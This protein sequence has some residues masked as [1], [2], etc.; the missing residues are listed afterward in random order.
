MI[1]K[2][3]NLLE[4]IITLAEFKE[5][6]RKIG[7]SFTRNR[8]LPF[9]ELVF[10]LINSCKKSLQI[11]INNFFKFIGED[12]EYSKQALCKARLNILPEGFRELNN[13]W[14]KDVYKENE[15]N[16]FNGYRILA[17]DGTTFELP[18]TEDLKEEF[19]EIKN[20]NGVLKKALGRASIL[21]DV[22]N[23]LVIDGV[24]DKY[25]S[26]E[27]TMAISHLE[28]WSKFKKEIKDNTKDLNIFDRGYPSV[29]LISYMINRDT[30][31]LMRIT[32][33]FLSETNEVISRDGE[34]DEIVEINITK[35]KLKN[36]IRDKRARNEVKLGDKIKVRVLK[37]ML[38]TG[39]YEYL[40]TSL[41]DKESFKKEMFKELY[42]KRW[43][44]ET[45][46]DKLKN[47]L[48]IEN[49][50][51]IKSIVIKQEFY[52]NILVNNMCSEFIDEVQKEIDEES[53]NKNNKYVYIVNR[54]YALGTIKGEFANL[55]FAKP[56]READRIIN[57]I[58]K[59][60]KKDKTPIRDGRSFPRDMDKPCNKYPM[61][62]KRVF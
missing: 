34:V 44:V 52:I 19:G 62:R 30:D 27:R 14:V 22:E 57:R 38:D 58:K 47:T 7:T 45:A 53:K 20:N 55:I 41:L 8:K 61:T 42:F 21:Y 50:S 15:F 2:R 54:N 13:V 36:S 17:I 32:K 16:T 31:F 29:Y 43:G 56:G 26:S 11:E 5:K 4:N 49:F 10:F 1:N 33:S 23:N 46:Y 28:T 51:G 9:A 39:N 18:Y 25:T 40:I 24:L 37:I 6:F 60:L 59:L 12:M 48:E 3:I 35:S